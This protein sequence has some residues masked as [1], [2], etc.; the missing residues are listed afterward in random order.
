[1]AAPTPNTQETKE[2]APAQPGKTFLA[3]AG[4]T[5]YFYLVDCMVVTLCQD[6]PA[7]PWIEWGIH[8]GGPAGFG[9]TVIAFLLGVVHWFREVAR[10]ADEERN[11]GAREQVR[12]GQA[13]HGAGGGFDQGHG[14]R[15][16]LGGRGKKALVVAW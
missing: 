7:G 2:S 5:C 16:L 9:V 14:R 1:M 12:H 10:K 4:L 8:A 6:H 15:D 13:L 11:A 3:V